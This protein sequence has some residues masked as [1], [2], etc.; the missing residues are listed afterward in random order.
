MSATSRVPQASGPQG[1]ID[2]SWPLAPGMPMFPGD[3]PLEYTR[4]GTYEA[5]GYLSHLVRLP[6]HNGTHVDAPGHVLPGGAM[7]ADLPL[8]RFTGAGVLLD[9]RGR[10]GLAVTAADLVPHLPGLAAQSPAFVLLRTGDE[11]RFGQ[12]EYFTRGAHLTPEAADLLAGLA[13]L[14]GVGLDAASADPLDAADLP[15]HRVLLGAGLIIVENLR[16]L[17]ALPAQAFRF[18]CLPVL[19]GDGSPVR[20]AALVATAGQTAGADA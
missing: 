5:N 14:S 9:L 2:L 3:P 4:M 16:N 12:E 18:L 15:A 6:A 10:A 1:L 19:G 7:L 20:A 11:A 17:A 8:S 13:G